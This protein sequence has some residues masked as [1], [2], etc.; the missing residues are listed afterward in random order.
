MTIVD[1]WMSIFPYFFLVNKSYVLRKTKKRV[2][3]FPVFFQ[4]LNVFFKIQIHIKKVENWDEYKLKW[5]MIVKKN[6]HYQKFTLNWIILKS[7]LEI[8]FKNYLTFFGSFI[9]FFNILFRP[10]TDKSYLVGVPCRC[11]RSLRALRKH[12]TYL[13]NYCNN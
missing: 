8:K 11:Y 4:I 10:L 5:A 12:L 1:N 2:N 9:R 6:M 13:I 3:F 7:N